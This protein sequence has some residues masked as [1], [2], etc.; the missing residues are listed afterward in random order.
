MDEIFS[1]PKRP[2]GLYGPPNLLLNRY[3]DLSLGKGGRGVKL[4]DL[5]HKVHSFKMRRV[6]LH[7]PLRL[8]GVE[9]SFK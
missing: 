8:L 3:G 1:S 2:D 7:Y 9:L 4:T 6:I 5:L